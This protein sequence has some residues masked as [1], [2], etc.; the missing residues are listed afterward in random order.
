MLG[1][2]LGSYRLEAHI[3]SGGMGVVYRAEHT[4]I[5]RKAAVKVLLPEYST[6]QD[7]I[8][9]FFNEAKAAASA[10]HPGI[11]EVYDFG[12]APDGTAYLV[13]EL[14]EGDTLWQRLRKSIRLPERQAL[15]IARQI[16][17]ALAAAHQAG[18]IHRDLKPGNIFLLESDDPG[19]LR[20][21]LMDFGVAKLMRDDSGG[22]GLTTTG[23]I[24]GTPTFMAPEQ[25]RG[26][27]TPIDWRSDLYSLGCILFAML[28][29]RPPFVADGS[30][31]VLAMHIYEPVP[32]V[33]DFHPVSDEVDRLVYQLLAKR[34]D[35]RAREIRE[36]TNLLAELAPT[37]EGR[38]PLVPTVMEDDGLATPPA[39]AAPASAVSVL[40]DKLP[41]V[42]FPRPAT[43]LRSDTPPPATGPQAPTLRKEKPGPVGGVAAAVAVTVPASAAAPAAPPVIAGIQ[44][45]GKRSETPPGWPDGTPTARTTIPPRA[46]SIA[47]R[48]RGAGPLAAVVLAVALLGGSLFAAFRFGVFGGHEKE[49]APRPATAPAPRAEPPPPPPAPVTVVKDPGPP[50]EPEPESEPAVVAEQAPSEPPAAKSRSKAKKRAKKSTPL[51]REAPPPSPSEDNVLDPFR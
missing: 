33:K 44:V 7:L 45:V 11:V 21:K 29:G 37:E 5:G 9:R 17:A 13:M 34:P 14:L 46:R 47:M 36:V 8:R 32:H 26:G 42:A 31:A 18:V 35:E 19:G 28:A 6:R 3:G 39:F 24:V 2:T 20:V 10:Q 25:C 41:P 43:T 12:R 50:P 22:E 30:G 27:G 38:R 15:V 16:A 40:R 23:A 1:R 4:L 48:R 51:A 49:A